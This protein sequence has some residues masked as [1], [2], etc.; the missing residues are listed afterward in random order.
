MAVIPK[1]KTTNVVL[2]D[3]IREL[4]K[5]SDKTK[6]KVYRAVAVKLAV[7]ASQKVELNVSKIDKY[8]KANETMIIPGKVLGSGTISKKV[9]VVAFNASQSAQKKIISAGGSFLEIRDYIAKS[10]KN[11][12]KILA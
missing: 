4:K 5:Y 12:L 7:P 9:N 6:T 11:K 2:F 8:A 1:S 10:P 3:T